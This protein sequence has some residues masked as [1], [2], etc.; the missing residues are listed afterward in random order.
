MDDGL[1]LAVDSRTVTIYQNAGDPDYPND[2][3]GI[4]MTIDS[5]KR[6][7]AVSEAAF[8]IKRAV[9]P[10]PAEHFDA[11]WRAYPRKVAKD[12]AKRAW[13]AVCGDKNYEVIIAA[14]ETI[15]SSGEWSEVQYIPH[16]ASWLNGRRWLDV[17]EVESNLGSF[18]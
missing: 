3:I 15:A 11:F 17:A 2:E 9:V 18:K 14:V 4:T 6:I 1:R 16:P 7:V 12:A 10:K 13:G 5:W 8:G